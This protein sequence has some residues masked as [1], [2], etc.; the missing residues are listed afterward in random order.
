M[1]KLENGSGFFPNRSPAACRRTTIP[2]GMRV[3]AKS[4][5]SGS[6]RRRVRPRAWLT[7][8][9][10]VA[11][12]A[13]VVVSSASASSTKPTAVLGGG[14]DVMFHVS[15]A[16]DLLYDE[17]P[18]CTTIA[19]TG[20]QP[21]DNGCIPQAGDPTTEDR[22]HDRISESYPI[23]GSAGVTQLCEQGLA[24]V[25]KIS[26]VRQTSAPSATVCTGL[27]YVAFARDAL[28]LTFPGA[29]GSDFH[30]GDNQ[31]G[32]CSGSTDLC[33]TQ[34]QLQGIFVN[35]TIT[36]WN[37]VGGN[38]A[39]IKIFTVL[40]QYGTRKAWDLFLGGSSSS[41]GATLVDQTDNSEIPAASQ[42]DAI[43]P[44]SVGSWNERYKGNPGG[45]A[46]GDVD[47]VAPTPTNIQN[48][49]FVY[50]RFLY[51]VY[52]AGD[53]T[54]SNKCGTAP[55]AATAT[56]RYIGFNGWIC[57]AASPRRRPDHR[58]RLPHRDRQHDHPVRV[59]APTPRR[60]RR[61]NHHHQLLPAGQDLIGR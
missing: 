28:T 16:L 11:V 10:L 41:C 22:Y 38:N 6:G 36:N 1:E 2:R 47:G 57:K 24:N 32:A 52:C 18:G 21:L 37:Q 4:N 15:S 61:R 56:V 27:D 3:E 44:V 34:A 5:E 23:G 13:G 39:P 29:S 12:L 53:P 51:N 45:S 55:K 35:C 33:L 26:Y 46:I 40:P 19:P 8:V 9:V 25:A 42:A 60:N 14:S 7:A 30:A 20:T 50:S 43:V 49:S 17:S 31:S 59:R 58:Y 54:K 48:G